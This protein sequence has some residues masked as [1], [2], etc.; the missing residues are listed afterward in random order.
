MTRIITLIKQTCFGSGTTAL[1]CRN[2]SLVETAESTIC[3]GRLKIDSSTFTSKMY[4]M[5]FRYSINF[6]LLEVTSRFSLPTCIVYEI[7]IPQKAISCYVSLIK[8]QYG[9]DLLMSM[10]DCVVFQSRLPKQLPQVIF[11]VPSSHFQI[12]P[13]HCHCMSKVLPF[14]RNKW[15]THV[16]QKFSSSGEING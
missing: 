6:Y 3:T 13:F 8:L 7:Y 14:W 11:I 16:S 1:L 5:I 12:C 10:A 2:S 4:F 9:V 15:L